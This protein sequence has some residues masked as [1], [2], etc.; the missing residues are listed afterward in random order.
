MTGEYQARIV[1]WKD[2]AIGDVILAGKD[3]L[4]VTKIEVSPYGRASRYLTVRWDEDPDH[5]REYLRFDE[6]WGVVV[7]GPKD[8]PADAP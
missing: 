6:D 2:V 7:S 8:D 1:R 4:P 5:W 3:M